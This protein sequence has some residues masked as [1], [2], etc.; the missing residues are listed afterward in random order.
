MV[1]VSDTRVQHLREQYP[2]FDVFL[3]RFTDEFRN[4]LRPSVALVA[5]GA[6]RSVFTI[7]AISS[8]RDIVA[9]SAVPLSRALQLQYGRPFP[10]QYSNSFALYPWSISKDYKHLVLNTGAL[11]SMN[12]VDDFEGQSSPEVSFHRV[13]T[14]DLDSVLLTELIKR[15]KSRYA[16]QRTKWK[17]RA[18]FRSL[19]MANQA[20]QIP[21]TAD[22]TRY[23]RGRITALWVSAFEILVHPGRGGWSGLSQVLDLLEQVD[24]Q[25]E[26]LTRKVYKV[27]VHKKVS[28][29]SFACSVYEQMYSARNDFLHGNPVRS[30]RLYLRGTKVPLWYC[31]ALLYRLGLT[32]FLDLSWKRP[33]PPL[34][35]TKRFANAVSDRY[36]FQRAQGTIE[37]GL[38]Y[39][40]KPPPE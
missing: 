4:A 29:R 13:R 36:D 2:T 10:F 7:D 22:E 1:G 12:K 3:S 16:T 26:F 19:N 20:A 30:S 39:A 21:W 24:W 8:F 37:Q 23:D 27:R 18:L 32:A 34:S 5:K 25:T 31:A 28:R 14:S 40:T 38:H 33:L 9:I 15:W 17:D 35:D 6:P 11:T